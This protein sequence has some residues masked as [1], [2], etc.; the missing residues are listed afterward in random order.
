MRLLLDTNAYS[1]LREGHAEVAGQVRRAERVLLSVVV[2][3]ELFYGFRHGSRYEDNRRS[4]EAFLD[5]PYVIVVPITVTTADRFGRIAASLRRKGRPI[6]TN[7]VWVA[8]HAM[9]TGAELVTFDQHFQQID[10]LALRFL[11]V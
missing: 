5:H 6:P 7:D 9:E 1:A 2:L 11:P 3:G 8:A 10:G 4:L